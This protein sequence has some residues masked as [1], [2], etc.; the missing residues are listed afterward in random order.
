MSQAGMC[1]HL[2]VSDA[3]NKHFVAA[4]KLKRSPGKV[5]AGLRALEEGP[6]TFMEP[7]RV[8]GSAVSQGSV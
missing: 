2:Y 4:S 1:L 6:L 3:R 5:P 7:L 8:P